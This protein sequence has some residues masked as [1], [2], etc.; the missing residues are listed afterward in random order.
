M[1]YVPLKQLE[2][3][4]ISGHDMQD[5]ISI[6]KSELAEL[7]EKSFYL[8]LIILYLLD[9]KAFAEILHVL[10]IHIRVGHVHSCELLFTLPEH[11]IT[12]R[13]K[14]QLIYHRLLNLFLKSIGAFK[15]KRIRWSLSVFQMLYH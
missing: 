15:C 8:S 4:D 7:Q 14:F 9:L 6:A 3:F 10:E 1:L 2:E 13:S 11:S 12:I 5:V